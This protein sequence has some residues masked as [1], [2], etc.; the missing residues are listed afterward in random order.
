MTGL[1]E[2]WKTILRRINPRACRAPD[3]DAIDY[4]KNLFPFVVTTFHRVKRFEMKGPRH[5]VPSINY[6]QRFLFETYGTYHFHDEF[7]LPRSHTKVMALNRVMKRIAS[8][9]GLPFHPTPL[10]KRPKLVN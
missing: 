1:R 3:H 2:K 7:P 9:L 8:E 4:S 10:L 6:I 5:N